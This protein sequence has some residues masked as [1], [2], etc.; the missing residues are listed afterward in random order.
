MECGGKLSKVWDELCNAFHVKYWEFYGCN[1]QAKAMK[2]YTLR[3]AA[4]L[5][6]LFS[7]TSCELV[8]DIFQAGMGIPRRATI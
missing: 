6:V 2:N 8:G 5:I 4:L 3:T 7:V 1:Q